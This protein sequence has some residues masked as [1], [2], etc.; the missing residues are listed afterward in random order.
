[1]SIFK[2]GWVRI[3][4]SVK[5]ILCE[6]LTQPSNE[7]YVKTLK[8]IKL[9]IRQWKNYKTIVWEDNTKDMIK[10]YKIR[11][12][13][14]KL[15]KYKRLFTEAK[16]VGILY[17]YIE[18][19]NFKDILDKDF[20]PS[21]KFYQ[22]IH[23][24]D[25]PLYGVSLTRFKN[26]SKMKKWYGEVIFVIDG[27][28]LSNIYKIVPTNDPYLKSGKTNRDFLLSKHY[29]NQ[30]EEFVIAPKGI[31]NF[32]RYILGIILPAEKWSMYTNIMHNNGKPSIF[33]LGDELLKKF[34]FIKGK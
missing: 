4:V 6:S 30:G 28:K 10:K 1:M 34:N 18:S 15:K 7:L 26:N 22:P 3:K 11:E 16:Q 21:G 33:Y 12:N 13:R 9:C 8:I 5:D 29:E 17:H 24:S 19:S 25:K 23:G 2:D 14:A 20:M 31:H 32:N 27:N